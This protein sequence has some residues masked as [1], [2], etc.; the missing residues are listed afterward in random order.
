MKIETERE[1]NPPFEVIQRDKP[2]L[3][4][5]TVAFENTYGLKSSEKSS[6]KTGRRTLRLKP[7]PNRLKRKKYTFARTNTDNSAALESVELVRSSVSTIGQTSGVIR[8]AVRGTANGVGRI[9]TMVKSG[10]QIHPLKSAGRIVS[11][12]GGG[13]NNIAKDTGQQ[14]LK[15][16]ID[17]TT[18]TDTGT[19]SIKQGLTDLRYAD[20][21]RKAVGNTAKSA[22]KTGRAIKNAP[23]NAKKQAERIRRNAKRAKEAAKKTASA[24]KTIVTSKVGLIIILGAA[25]ILIIVMLFNGLITMIISAVSSMFSW[26]FPDGDTSDS[27]IQNN[28]SSYISQLQ[29]AEAEKQT[30][31]DSIVNSLLP[32]YRYDGS[33]IEGL[34]QIKN[35]SLQLCDYNAVLAV[36]A[37]QKY[38]KVLEGGTEDFHFTDEEIQNAVEMFYNF[39][40]HYEYDYCPNW[41]CAKDVDCLLSLSDG[42]FEIIETVFNEENDCYE[43]TM[44]GTTYEQASAMYTKLEIYMTDGG[45]ITGSGSADVD[46][47][48]WTKTYN[49]STDAYNQIDWDNFYL[50]VDTT[51][52]NNPNH[53]Y[54]YGDVVNYG[55]ETVMYRCNFSEDERS[56]FELYCA[57]IQAMG[58]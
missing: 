3:Q 20:N 12:V 38:Q 37:V 43:V 26:M 16:K 30:E 25:L 23:Q 11:A 32:E 45:T 15:T 47:G 52:C 21:A 56:I 22:V 40:Y 9:Q 42:S 54:L 46:G 2:E 10:V 8:T 50:T 24:V 36:L 55:T 29:N 39:S 51:Y 34:N 19:E 5:Y 6:L 57:E 14:M 27:I 33:Q 58:D 53:C 41:D 18:I 35:S 17:K 44:Q 4:K 1:R 48:V 7:N 28:I 49:I 13:V 31:I